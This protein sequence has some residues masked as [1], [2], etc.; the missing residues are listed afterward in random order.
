MG[1]GSA[2]PEVGGLEFLKVPPEEAEVRR[3]G[4]A[5]VRGRVCVVEMWASWCPPCRNVAPHLSGIA[6]R[7]RSRGLC[8]VGVTS[9]DRGAVAG[10]VAGHKEMDYAVA[11]DAGGQVQARLA[12]PAGVRGIPHAFV[13]DARGRVAYSGHPADPG[14][15]RAVE[16][17]V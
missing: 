17:A 14:F 13:V 1:V 12:G 7:F 3:G 15:E 4:E 9:E 16:A 2:C 6:R 5:W 8:V 10:F 11:V